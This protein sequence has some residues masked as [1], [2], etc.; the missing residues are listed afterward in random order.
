VKR[1]DTKKARSLGERARRIGERDVQW[2]YIAPLDHAARSR[3]LSSERPHIIIH[4]EQVANGCCIRSV[5]DER[6]DVSRRRAS[7]VVRKG[8]G[9]WLPCQA[10]RESLG[11]LPM[12]PIRPGR[13]A[14]VGSVR[15]E[16]R[17]IRG[18]TMLS[19]LLLATSNFLGDPSRA[20]P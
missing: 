3:P 15:S 2:S 1:G 7:R 8:K 4:I 12:C 14:M 19:T 11:D 17:V 5:V 9:R 13:M 18:R 16:V 6:E 20:R 10:I